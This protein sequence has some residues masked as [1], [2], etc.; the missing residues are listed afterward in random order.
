MKKYKIG[1]RVKHKYLGKGTFVRKIQIFSL[2]KWDKIPPKRYNGS[3]N[4]T[5]IFTEELYSPR[6]NK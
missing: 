3:E 1:D 2:V 4:P 5:I 6:D